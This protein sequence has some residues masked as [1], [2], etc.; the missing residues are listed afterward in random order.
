MLALPHFPLEWPVTETGKELGLQGYM[1]RLI[2]FLVLL[3]GPLAWADVTTGFLGS[4][5][6]TRKDTV[7]HHPDTVKYASD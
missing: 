1:S 6:S 5:D 2:A 7:V 3:V 4:G